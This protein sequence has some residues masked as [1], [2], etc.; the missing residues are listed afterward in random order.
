MVPKCKGWL[1]LFSSRRY[2]II[3]FSCFLLQVAHCS[4]SHIFSL[5][6][7]ADCFVPCT[8]A[9]V[10]L[11]FGSILRSWI[12]AFGRRWLER[13]SSLFS[14]LLCL[15]VTSQ[16]SLG[17]DWEQKWKKNPADSDIHQAVN[18]NGAVNTDSL[19]SEV[20]QANCKEQ[21]SIFRGFA[22]YLF[23]LIGANVKHALVLLKA[24]QQGKLKVLGKAA[25]HSS[26]PVVPA[27]PVWSAQHTDWAHCADLYFQFG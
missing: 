6:F 20:V 25:L 12:T 3:H 16:L 27:I 17:K 11:P 18:K 10:F 9:F 19:C 5:T 13:L 4:C 1:Q 22:I 24:L 14:L 21:F 8:A 26:C 15:T 23:V 2:I 7:P